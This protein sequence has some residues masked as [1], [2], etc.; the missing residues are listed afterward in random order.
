MHRGLSPRQRKHARRPNADMIVPVFPLTFQ[1]TSLLSG[2]DPDPLKAPAQPWPS[3][4]TVIMGILRTGRKITQSVSSGI[5]GI[6]LSVGKAQFT[7]GGRG[8]GVIGKYFR[9]RPKCRVRQLA[10][11]CVAAHRIIYRLALEIGQDI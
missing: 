4:A 9:D 8:I 5:L 1:T 2:R 6:G 7:A 10:I 3:T 11:R